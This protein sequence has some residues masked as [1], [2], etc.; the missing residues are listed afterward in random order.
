MAASLFVKE[1]AI[2]F[3]EILAMAMFQLFLDILVSRRCFAV[4]YAKT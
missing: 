1:A 4:K 3:T 2:L